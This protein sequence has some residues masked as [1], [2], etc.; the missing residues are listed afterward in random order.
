[1]IHGGL[2]IYRS[3]SQLAEAVAFLKS[4]QG[5]V[6]LVTIEIGASD[7]DPC[8]A[9]KDIKMIAPCF[10]RVIP[11][12][13]ENLATIMTALTKASP[14]PVKIIGTAYGNPGVAVWLQGTATARTLARD[15]VALARGYATDLTKVY[16]TFGA[17]VANIFDAFHNGDFEPRVMLP[18][19]GSVPEN[20]ACACAY[21]WV[22]SA[23]PTGGNELSNRLGYA[24]MASAFLAADLGVPA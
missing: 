18:P 15:G 22:C 6:Q 4:H 11:K 3:G 8:L 9:L 20:V 21:T 13:V 24:V 23:P 19:F 17:G 7:L 5:H 16:T 12:A 10:A 2:C 1:M 14:V